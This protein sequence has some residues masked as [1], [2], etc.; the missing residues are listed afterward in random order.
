M[1]DSDPAKVITE[2]AVN[3][4]APLCEAALMRFCRILGAVA[5][6]L[7]LTCMATGGIFLGGGILPKILPVLQKS[8]FLKSYAAKGRFASFVAAIPVHVIRN[9]KAALMGAAQRAFELAD[10][11]SATH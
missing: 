11:G 7:A 2:H 4:T 10:A 8:D 5:G 1:I 3:G 9:D 6:N